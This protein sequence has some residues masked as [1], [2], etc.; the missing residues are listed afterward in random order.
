ML[1][2]IRRAAADQPCGAEHWIDTHQ[3]LDLC[4]LKIS[5]LTKAGLDEETAEAVVRALK[6]QDVGP[7]A[8][9]LRINLKVK[10]KVWAERHHGTCRI[11]CEGED[12]AAWL[13]DFLV[14]HFDDAEISDLTPVEGLD[15]IA[16]DVTLTP[17]CTP[18]R[19]RQALT[20]CPATFPVRLFPVSVA[21]Q[22]HYVVQAR[23]LGDWLE[24]QEDS[25]DIWWTVD[26]DPTLMSRME[27]PA[28]PDE[29]AQELRQINNPL[30]VR[31][32]N[33]TG[34][35]EEITPEEISNV[36]ESDERG[37]RSFLMCWQGSNNDW[38]LIEDEPTSESSSGL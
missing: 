37:N 22:P 36:A 17:T 2:S 7:L 28:P 9:A 33:E 25:E 24:N 30:L 10:F 11:R 20:K 35:G 6:K 32:P 19:I 38:E 34:N 23:S 26:G 27:F 16:F 8:N 14:Q 4:K 29:L 31:D 18:Y 5:D 13:R 1:E 15:E 21:E 3:K 12:N